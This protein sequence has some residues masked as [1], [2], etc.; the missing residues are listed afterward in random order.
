MEVDV[1]PIHRKGA[2]MKK[3]RIG[4]AICSLAFVLSISACGKAEQEILWIGQQNAEEASEGFP[5]NTGEARSGFPQ[6]TGEVWFGQP[7]DT[8]EARSGQP[9]DTGKAPDIC[10]YVCGAVETPG[11]VFLPEGSRAADALEAAGGFASH[12]A[13][14]AVNLAAK[15]SDGEKLYFPDC[16]EYRA[17][18]EKQASASAGLVNINTADAAQLCTLPGIGESRAADIIA[19]REAHGGFAS[20]EDIMNVSG[21]KES[22]Y[23]KISDKIT[24]AP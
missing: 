18:A 8:G 11:I 24:T 6:D 15:I 10:V 20:C 4:A 22:V 23:N 19:Y 14:D 16:E 9:Q 12:A 3:K 5:Q 21:I 13:V 7:Q 1:L 2:M 17:Q